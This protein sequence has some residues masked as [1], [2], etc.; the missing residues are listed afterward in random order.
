MF[1]TFGRDIAQVT[2]GVPSGITRYD[3]SFN[4]TYRGAFW[5]VLPKSANLTVVDHDNLHF[6]YRAEVRPAAM[7]H[8]ADNWLAVFDTAA[9]SAEVNR[10]ISVLAINADAVQFNDPNAT[11]VAFANVDPHVTTGATLVWAIN[12][13]SAQ[14]IAGLT[15]GASYGIS[16]A[17]GNMTVSSIGPYSASVA[18]VLVHRK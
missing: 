5:S 14:Y 1:W 9:S 6:L 17:G 12:G 16:T 18:G 7:D 8:A 2:S 10:V 15:P 3:A 4:G 11:I 13:S